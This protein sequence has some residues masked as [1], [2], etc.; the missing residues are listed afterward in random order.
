MTLLGAVAM[1]VAV[2]SLGLAA[3]APSLPPLRI[4]NIDAAL[5]AQVAPTWS[6]ARWELLRLACLAAAVTVAGALGVWPLGVL[7]AAAPSVA[8]RW[9]ER[10]AASL[11]AARSLDVLQATQ[12]ALRAG[13]PLAPALRAALE[14]T[15][16]LVRD[17]FERALRAFEL[18]SPFAEALRDAAA[19]ARDRRVALA[20]EALALVAGEQLP[21]T[22]AAAV[23]GSVADRLSFDARLLEEVRAS[24]S[25]VR[26]QIILLAL[27]VPALASYLVLTMPGLAATLGGPLGTH[28]LVPAALVF[29]VAGI[30]ASRRIVRGL[31]T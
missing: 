4:R 7:G 10:Q 20:L 26:A 23:V 9:R 30:V 25:G 15:S 22:R 29:E 3:C 12:A 21:S 28:V 1:G 6:L 31:A 14:R 5:L 17:P 8:L 27:L 24:T 2:A 19:A 13:L 11:A 16:P 18:N